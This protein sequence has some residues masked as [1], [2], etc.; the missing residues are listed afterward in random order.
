MAPLCFLQAYFAEEIF[1]RFPLLIYPLVGASLLYA[2]Y[3][4][5]VL[6]RLRN[7]ATGS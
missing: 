3:A 5:W 6:S 2:A 1:T 4:V 7:P